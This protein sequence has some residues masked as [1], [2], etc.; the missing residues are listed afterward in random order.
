MELSIETFFD[1]T[2]RMLI[3]FI[4]FLQTRCKRKVLNQRI[5]ARSNNLEPGS[6]VLTPIMMEAHF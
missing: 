2:E 3:I 5:L 1:E 6:K 4:E